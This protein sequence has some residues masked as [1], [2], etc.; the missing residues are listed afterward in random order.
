MWTQVFSS[1]YN[2]KT[3]HSMY[4]L[5]QF[6]TQIYFLQNIYMS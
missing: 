4:S 5:V 1:F 6:T 3:N 2:V